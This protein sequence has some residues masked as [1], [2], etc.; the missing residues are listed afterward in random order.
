[1]SKFLLVSLFFLAGCSVVQNRPW[2]SRTTPGPCPNNTHC[3]VALGPAD[4]PTAAA[5][6]QDEVDTLIQQY[7][8]QAN[9]ITYLSKSVGVLAQ[10]TCGNQKASISTVGNNDGIAV[11]CI[12][13][14]YV[15]NFNEKGKATVVLDKK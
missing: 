15:L 13:R 1:M 3:I 6:L 10:H 8:S 9:Q 4:Q 7:K 5:V 14:H 11:R 2:L 12:G